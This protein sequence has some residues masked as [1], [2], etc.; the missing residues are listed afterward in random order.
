METRSDSRQKLV[1]GVKCQRNSI[2]GPRAGAGSRKQCSDLLAPVFTGENHTARV[3]LPFVC[4]FHSLQKEKPRA[5]ERL[6]L[7]RAPASW[8]EQNGLDSFS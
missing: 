5:S 6:F 3:A 1:G 7:R 8:P 2:Q 4:Y